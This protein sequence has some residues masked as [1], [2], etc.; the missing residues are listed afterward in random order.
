MAVTCTNLV[1][2]PVAATRYKRALCANNYVVCCS[3]VLDGDHLVAFNSL[4]PKL[5]GSGRR[6]GKKALPK[7]GIDPCSRHDARPVGRRKHFRSTVRQRFGF[8]RF[9]KSAINECVTQ[10]NGSSL[11]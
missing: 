8:A 6:M 3:R 9:Y 1:A 2:S 5:V 4:D 7:I 11:R 10:S